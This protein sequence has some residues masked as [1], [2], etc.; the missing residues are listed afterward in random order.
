MLWCG[1]S[2]LE[3]PLASQFSTCLNNEQAR[4]NPEGDATDQFVDDDL[5][6]NGFA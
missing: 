4:V 1:D 2:D 5:I 3:V 6:Q